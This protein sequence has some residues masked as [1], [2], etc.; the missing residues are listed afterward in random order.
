MLAKR[1]LVQRMEV[2]F[3]LSYVT[4]MGNAGEA[5]D[6]G[7]SYCRSTSQ[8]ADQARS[9]FPS[10][11]SVI[12]PQPSV[13]SICVKQNCFHGLEQVLTEGYFSQKGNSLLIAAH[14]SRCISNATGKLSSMFHGLAMWAVKVLRENVQDRRIRINLDNWTQSNSG[15][16]ALS[17]HFS[18]IFIPNHLNLILNLSC[19]GR[20]L[21]HSEVRQTVHLFHLPL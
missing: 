10:L 12:C 16:S 18:H 8:R 9:L 17:T 21:F 19:P 3:I 15:R 14:N 20:D 7:N 6:C 1:T 4:I 2:S 11:L 5:L 13:C